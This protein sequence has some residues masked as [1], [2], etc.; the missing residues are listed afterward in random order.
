MEC[1]RVPSLLK[2]QEKAD[3]A[4]RVREGKYEEVKPGK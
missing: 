2:G 4:E 3:V 1:S